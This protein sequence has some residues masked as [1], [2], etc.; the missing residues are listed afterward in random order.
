MSQ[1][2]EFLQKEGKNIKRNG[3]IFNT[4]TSKLL[5]P[6]VNCTIKDFGLSFLNAHIAQDEPKIYVIC[7][8]NEDDATLI[9]AIV[10][11]RI[12]PNFIDSVV[13]EDER[14][15]TF[16]IKEEDVPI[17]EA[18]KKGRYSTFPIEYKERLL[19]IY[20]RTPIKSNRYVSEC[21][22]LYPT[23][24][25]RKQIADWLG[26]KDYREIVEVL[27]APDLSYEFYVPITELKSKELN[28]S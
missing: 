26:V 6:V 19:K 23:D 14:I 7:E 28:A 16:K 5:L 10:K 9:T 25:K 12:N 21:D 17:Y 15:F 13:I 22:A 4:Y 8:N 27:D 11:A 3:D 18:F 1:R 20:G 2:K 24:F